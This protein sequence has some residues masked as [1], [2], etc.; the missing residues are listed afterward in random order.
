MSLVT[1]YTVF[2]VIATLVNLLVQEL[3]LL[4]YSDRFAL[5]VAILAGTLA[6]LYTKF[7]LDKRYIFR[8]QTEGLGEHGKHFLLYSLMGV[9][10]TMIFWGM[11]LSFDYFFQTKLMRY[12]GAV[13]GLSIGYWVKYQLDKRFVFIRR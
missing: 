6:G 8:F 1:L 4:I 13:L 10:T 2:A 11:E 3:S 9:F 7:I 12:V 5:Y